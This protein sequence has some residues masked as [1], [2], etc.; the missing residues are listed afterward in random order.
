MTPE[1]AGLSPASSEA[2]PA[3]RRMWVFIAVGAALLVVIVLGVKFKRTRDVGEP[4]PEMWSVGR[5]VEVGQW[6]VRVV[7]FDWREES[8]G[9]EMLEVRLNIE[10]R[11]DSERAVP[12]I[13]LGDRKGRSLAASFGQPVMKSATGDA[14]LRVKPGAKSGGILLFPAPPAEFC[15]LV[16][17]EGSGTVA[18]NLNLHDARLK[19]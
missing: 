10:N 15:L 6:L 1:P 14:I 12:P 3:A 2:P 17:A 13:M 16:A 18:I 9:V 8:Q 4:P 5:D 7:S 19:E 11:A